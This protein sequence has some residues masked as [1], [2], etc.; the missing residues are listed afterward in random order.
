[1]HHESV[2]A[3]TVCLSDIIETKN[4]FG[5]IIP[6]FVNDLLD[7]IMLDARIRMHFQRVVDLKKFWGTRV[8]YIFE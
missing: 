8:E 1:M 6:N 5:S 7:I 2:N 4:R 3:Q